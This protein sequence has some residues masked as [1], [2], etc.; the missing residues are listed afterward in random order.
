[1]LGS[2]YYAGW[3][4]TLLWMPNFSNTY[5]RAIFFRFAMV[6]NMVIFTIVMFSRSYLLTLSSIFLVGFFTSFR[7]GV[8]WPYLLEMIPKKDRPIHATLYGM[9]GASWGII[10]SLFFQFISKNVYAF[11]GIGYFMQIVSLILTFMLPES[12][13]YLL[14]KGKLEEAEIALNKIAKINN[15]LLQFNPKDFKDWDMQDQMAVILDS[16]GSAHS[17]MTMSPGGKRRNGQKEEYTFSYYFRQKKIQ[18]NLAVMT[19]SWLTCSLNNTLI[20]FLL[21]YM[22]GELFFNGFMSCSS[23]LVGTFVSG[24]ALM[25]Y[26][27]IQCLKVSYGVAGA[28]GVMMLIYLVQTKYYSYE[29]H[30]FT[31]ISVFIFGSLILIVKFGCSAAF[32]VLYGTTTAMFPPLFSVSA[33]SISNFLARTCTF[34]SPQIAEI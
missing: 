32:N 3:C 19:L 6:L 26:D 23:E 7:T 21:K 12:P 20:S 24:V 13:V 29:T 16:P 30:E 2:L 25:K 11:M 9:M 27:S 5:G 10:G 4:S 28:G 15:R 18:I 34:F 33:F 31:L 17:A 22:P 8:G 14:N 1:M